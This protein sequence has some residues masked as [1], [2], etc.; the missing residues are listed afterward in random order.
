MIQVRCKNKRF[1]NAGQLRR[2]NRF[3][4]CLPNSI[5]AVLKTNGDKILMR[6]P[7]C[8]SNRFSELKYVKGKLTFESVK[9]PDL[10]SVESVIFD[11]MKITEEVGIGGD[12]GKVE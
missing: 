4:V 7:S 12:N 6:C 9:S 2:C 8:T 1:D 5:L 11:D 10:E 3:L